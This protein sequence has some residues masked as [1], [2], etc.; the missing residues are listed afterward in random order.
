[1]A[2]EVS[3][4]EHERIEQVLLDDEE[5]LWADKPVRR[6]YF[7]ISLTAVLTTGLIS[8]VVCTLLLL[9]KFWVVIGNEKLEEFSENVE[10]T[11]YIVGGLF[12]LGFIL[13]F[14]FD[15]FRNLWHAHRSVYVVTDQ[16]VFV[17]RG[18]RIVEDFTYWEVPKDGL[19]TY[20]PIVVDVAEI[21]G[22]IKPVEE[23]VIRRLAMIH[24]V[25]KNGGK[26][27]IVFSPK[28][29]LTHGFVVPVK[30]F[31]GVRDVQH[32]ADLIRQQP[33]APKY[34]FQPPWYVRW[35][36]MF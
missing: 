22:V 24:V 28:F 21:V 23:E 3:E 17:M 7:R 33:Y 4:R 35:Q 29:S 9:L 18:K 10:I 6:L 32:V 12:A 20:V 16:R 15:F 1:M 34:T 19:S 2:R 14:G 5:L 30:A 31:A 27:H 25:E 8:I 26:G 11:I 36:T 13:V